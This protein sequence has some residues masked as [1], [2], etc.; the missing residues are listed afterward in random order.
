MI[1]NRIRCP[2][3]LIKRTRVWHRGRLAKLYHYG[4]TGNLHKWFDSYLSKRFQ[5]ITI[6]GGCSE[7]VKSKAGVPQCSILGL[8][9]FLYI[10]DI[11]HEIHS[12]LRLFADDTIYIIVDFPDS[13]AQIL[14]IDLERIAHWAA[15]CLVGFN[16]KK[17]ESLL[18]SRRLI[19][20]NH[21]PLFFNH[22]P[23]Q[24]Q[25]HKHL[26]IYFSDK[27]D[28][29][30]YLNHIQEKAWSR[31][32]LLRSMKFIMGRKSLQASKG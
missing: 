24:V 25:S 12:N 19:K 5:S 22:V 21:I 10:N 18:I 32:H 2:W 13:A 30:V 4:I 29:Q 3:L 27:C 16:A 9:L 7:W 6:P 31:L 11:V 8:F 28:W 14:N 17:T 15:E 1:V 26:G 20:L 23:I